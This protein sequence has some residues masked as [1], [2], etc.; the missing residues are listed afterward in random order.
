MEP[1][2]A[3]HFYPA[4]KDFTSR[5][6]RGLTVADSSARQPGGRG[7][8]GAPP[9]STCNPIP[10]P[11]RPGRID[12]LSDAE[13]FS[14]GKDEGGGGGEAALGWGVREILIKK[15]GF[16]RPGCSFFGDLVNESYE[17][18]EE[19][20][21]VFCRRLKRVTGWASTPW[22]RFLSV[23]RRGEGGASGTFA[24]LNSLRSITR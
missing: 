3:W 19:E 15:G 10:E 6:R 7:P 16:T 1:I 20:E 21:C 17:E 13:V 23:F 2:S 9:G 4:A 22:C 5:L 14:P 18:R 8:A 11:Q 24:L 12:F